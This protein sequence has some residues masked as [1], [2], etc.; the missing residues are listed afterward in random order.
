MEN[1]STI[2]STMA[3]KAT[4]IHG[5]LVY[6]AVDGNF[7]RAETTLDHRLAVDEHTSEKG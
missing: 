3:Q 5:L 7:R 1:W 4:H 6:G 2:K